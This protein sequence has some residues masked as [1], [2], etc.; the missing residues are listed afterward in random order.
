MSLLLPGLAP[1]QPVVLK[2]CRW[3]AKCKACGISTSRQSWDQNFRRMKD[4]PRREG[5]VYTYD[6]PKTGPWLATGGAYVI[7]CR[8][9][10]RPRI[11]NEVVGRFSSK[12]RCDARC[13][14]ATGN[15]CE[16]QCSGKNHGQL[17]DT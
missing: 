6:P 10:G 9:C 14:A 2:K 1:P 4:D 12:I 15:K 11:A 7:D 3:I 16:C 8:Q 17:F 5:G 13:Q